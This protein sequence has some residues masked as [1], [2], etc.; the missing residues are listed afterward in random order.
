[1]KKIPSRTKIFVG[2]VRVSNKRYI[3]NSVDHLKNP[4][5][6]MY[7]QNQCYE[8]GLAPKVY[9]TNEVYMI[10]EYVEEIELTINNKSLFYGENIARLHFMMQSLVVDTKKLRPM[11][12]FSCN[13]SEQK[14][15]KN[16][17]NKD[18]QVM[19]EVYNEFFNMINN[20]D[21][22]LL[23]RYLI[24][25][26]LNLSNIMITGAGVQFID[27]DNC[28]YFP[29]SYEVLRFFFQ[30]LDFSQNKEKT[31]KQ[32]FTYLTA[33]HSINKLKIQEWKISLQFYLSILVTDVSMIE[34]KIFFKERSNCARFIADNFISL[35]DCINKA[36]SKGEKKMRAKYNTLVIPFLFKDEPLFCI[37]KREDMK[38][39]Q[40]VA[41]GGEDDEA[42]ELGAARE[43]E[44]ETG[45]DKINANFLKRLDSQG[46]VPS[47]IF[48][49]FKESW[50]E[51]LYVIPIYTFSY[52]MEDSGIHLSEE[53]LE[54]KWVTYDQA[55]E[56][57]HYDLDKTA[58]WELK[59]R[60]E[61][62]EF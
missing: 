49:I 20:I 47:N 39:W 42:I 37:L 34:N 59:M 4:E 43:L 6:I 28:S 60:I 45:L 57:L 1:M 33:Y 14:L 54:Y 19:L 24:H 18:A 12:K 3:V 53:H 62:N 16:H 48:K 52:F 11:N 7:I 55:V 21:N 5:L 41:G 44:E 40:F 30:S 22:L 50:K 17:Q 58:L 8:A 46:T 31:I 36:T 15:K 23:D 10:Q 2:E 29:R 27:F 51:G 9:Y 25:G 56:L 32:L 61:N 35:Q 13:Y 38:I 26:D